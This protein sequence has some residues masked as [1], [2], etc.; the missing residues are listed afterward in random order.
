MN[1]KKLM[2]IMFCITMLFT[3]GVVLNSCGKENEPENEW[4]ENGGGNNGEKSSNGYFIK[5]PWAGGSWSWKS[6]TQNGSSYTYTG[7]WGGTG[8]NINTTASDN[9]ADWFPESEISGAYYVSEGDNVTFTYY[10]SS[11][12]LSV[13]SNGGGNNGGQNGGNNGG[14]NGGNN[15]GGNGGNNNDTTTKPD[16]PTGLT[17][18]QGGPLAL[19]YVSLSWDYVS[20]ADSYNIYRATS[21]NGS[22]TKIGTSQWSSYTDNSPK[23]GG[24]Y[25]KVTAVNSKGESAKS[26]YALCTIDKSAVAPSFKSISGSKSG[27]SLTLKWTL[28]TGSGYGKAARVE[29]YIYD[30]DGLDGEGWYQY[31][32]FTGSSINSGSYTVS[33]YT[34]YLYYNSVR[35]ALVA[36]NEYG[37]DRRT[38]I[39]IPDSNK[40]TGTF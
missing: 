38:I 15:E 12:S 26:D 23:D 16:A 24:N 36:A 3:T 40:W 37:E 18:T 14:G 35:M 10:P 29:V 25:Y 20:N 39:Y 1:V 8:A 4:S 32:T 7:I 27:S 22:Y 6:M 33:L 28:N 5:H 2:S 11:N 9:G 17:A 30:P 21:A 13:T 19:V 31:K 34:A